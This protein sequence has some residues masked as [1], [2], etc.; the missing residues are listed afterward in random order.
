MRFD[1][2]Y[3]LPLGALAIGAAFAA[4]IIG[5]TES[6]ETTPEEA[7]APLVRTV[8]VQ[9]E[10]FVHRVF[11]HGTVKPRTESDLTAEVAGRVIWISPNLV[12]G[13]YFEKDEALLR[14]DPHDYEVAL[15]RARANVTSSE[16]QVKLTVKELARQRK[17]ATRSVASEANLDAAINAE[18]G[19]SAARRVA[20][21]A[22]KQAVRDLA[23]TEIAAPYEGRVREETV[24]VGQWVSR[25]SPI[26]R[27]YAVDY[28][29][30]RLPV[31][32]AQLAFLDVPLSVARTEGSGEFPEVRLRA[33]FAGAPR[34]WSGRVVRTEGEI[35]AQTRMIHV[36]A[37]VD[38]PYR[39]NAPEAASDGIPLAVGLFVE[40]EITGREAR[41]VVVL[42]RAALRDG[43]R[44]FVID[45]DERLRFR[46]VDV[47]R[48]QRDRAVIG[49]GLASGEQVCISPIVAPV[50]GMR[51]RIAGRDRAP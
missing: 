35:D 23:R 2:R 15:E 51:V 45:A 26:A 42:P 49:A 13:G 50:D 39:R 9:L 17:L 28:A 29:E 48:R 37:R 38:D 11:T 19:A 43:D 24:D 14:I 3:L 5:S 46:D 22:L 25:G 27:L 32:D 33:E 47:V 10:T 6:P 31:P 34:V 40:A 8:T 1:P 36:V 4:I 20:R 21:A 44:V 16:S 18:R 7:P 12:S 30:V 41:D